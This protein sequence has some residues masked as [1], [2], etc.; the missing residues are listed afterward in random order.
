MKTSFLAITKFSGSAGKDAHNA[1]FLNGSYLDNV[2]AKDALRSSDKTFVLPKPVIFSPLL[3]DIDI[4]MC[5][6]C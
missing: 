4:V 3:C 5:N 2:Y 1:L 6:G